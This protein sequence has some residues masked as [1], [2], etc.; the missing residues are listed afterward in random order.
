M[1]YRLPPG[2]NDLQKNPNKRGFQHNS[3]ALRPCTGEGEKTAAN[4][5]AGCELP[6][7]LI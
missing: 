4:A 1:V 5:A 7:A 3:G 2:F 6:D